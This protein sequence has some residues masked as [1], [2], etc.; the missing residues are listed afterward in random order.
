MI[1]GRETKLPSDLK[2]FLSSEANKTHLVNFLCNDWTEVIPNKL[3]EGQKVV[4]GLTDG[5]VLE[6][7]SSGSSDLT[8]QS[9]IV[10]MEKKTREC[11]FTARKQK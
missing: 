4:L 10:I 3:T 1:Q 11:F 9:L 5:S 6:I 8:F 7:C 2:R